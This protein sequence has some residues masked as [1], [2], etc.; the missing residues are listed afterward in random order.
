M[1]C[2]QPNFDK[3][4]YGWLQLLQHNKIEIKDSVL[5]LSLRLLVEE[6]GAVG[7]LI[8]N[9]LQNL[10]TTITKTKSK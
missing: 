9:Y 7:K 5:W 3:L 10:D 8:N 1:F 2:F 4:S 6:I